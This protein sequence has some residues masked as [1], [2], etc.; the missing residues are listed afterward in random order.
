MFTWAGVAGAVV[1]FRSDSFLLSINSLLYR[2]RC[3]API[4]ITMRRRAKNVH[5]SNEKQGDQEMESIY[6]FLSEEIYTTWPRSTFIAED[7]CADDS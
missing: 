6:S 3:S 5:T 2:S 7:G 4:L 1:T